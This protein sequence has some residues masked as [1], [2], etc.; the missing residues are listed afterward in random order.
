MDHGRDVGEWS[1]KLQLWLTDWLLTLHDWSIRNTW[2]KPGKLLPP[3]PPLP[4]SHSQLAPVSDSACH[5][6]DCKARHPLFLVLAALC[7]IHEKCIKMWC[8]RWTDPI[9]PNDRLMPIGELLRGGGVALMTERGVVPSGGSWTMVATEQG[10]DRKEIA[11]WHDNGGVDMR[12]R[13]R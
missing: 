12:S 10:H 11:W 4:L 9:P 5:Q 7:T 13:I 1:K 6:C 8:A 3:F 2:H